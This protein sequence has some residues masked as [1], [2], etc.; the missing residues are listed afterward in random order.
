MEDMKLSNSLPGVSFSG[1]I[2]IN[3]PMFDIHDNQNINFINHREKH[4]SMQTTDE[5]NGLPTR[6]QM[7][8]AVKAT[9]KQG[10]WWSSRSWAVVY[11]VYQMK[12]YVRNY[13]NFVN[14]VKAWKVE[15][16]FE[17]TYDA[18]QKPIAYGLYVGFPEKWENNGASKQAVKF[19]LSL[20]KELEKAENDPPK[21]SLSF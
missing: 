10:M 19:A 7:I 12:G 9:V 5:P 20:L 4:A 16:G 14:E 8:Q 6:E 18:V 11:R 3:G 2:T 17:C 21:E 13:T 1:P 15:T